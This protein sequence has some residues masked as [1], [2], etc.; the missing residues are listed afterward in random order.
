MKVDDLIRRGG[1]SGPPKAPAS[2]A[3]L[4]VRPHVIA[5]LVVAL[6][7]AADA[8][9]G[10]AV[11]EFDVAG[12]K[13][14]VKK[15]ESTQTV[16]AGLFL[17]GGARN[18]TA[19]NAGIEPLMLDVS[20]E[21]SAA[22]PRERMRRELTGAGASLSFASSYDY[23]ALTLATPR[24]S[25]DRA[26]AVFVDAAL[27]PSFAADDFER[28]KARRL[29][30]LASIEDTPD[31]FV[32]DLT[33]RAAFAGHPYVNRPDGTVDSVKRV[34]IDDMRSYHQRMMVTSR[35]LLVVVGN[36][37][38]RDVRR[39]VESAF[40]KM[41]R[42]TYQRSAVQPLSFSAPTITITS[43]NLPTNYVRGI[44]AAPSLQ[45]ADI[46]AMRVATTILHDRVFEEVRAKR[47]LSY[48]PEAF[49]YSQGANTGGIY[50]T[51][52]DANQAAI[53]MLGEI[54]R[55]Q[56]D[57]VPTSLIRASA[58]GFLTTNFVGQE[59]NAAQAG[60]LAMYEL[61]GGGW[62]QADRVL[63]RVRAVTPADVR[64]VA[65]TY[66]KNI[67]FAVLGN[68]SAINREIFTRQP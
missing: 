9:V 66:M 30:S 19:E 57:E 61:I 48:A 41:A 51:A 17:D 10:T 20:T 42:G 24:H 36:I 34:T 53:L 32:D 11:E 12:L 54:S 56:R 65:S 5:L 4:R 35:L 45:S 44:F 15:R 27:N 63:E 2:R 26:W 22:F 21:A 62:Q 23:S 28:V 14:L 55:M 37:D 52:V 46:Y 39:K 13:V 38:A 18:V 50:F 59:T 16:V 68:P 43:R 47:N 25:F 58:Q 1:P 6:A 29:L 67:Q 40:A 64:R 3:D 49:L 7:G 60:T 33:A 8:Q 31:A